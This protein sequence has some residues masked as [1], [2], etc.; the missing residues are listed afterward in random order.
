M[1][2]SNILGVCALVGGLALAPVAAHAQQQS[3]KDLM[4]GTWSLLLDDGITADGTHVPNFGP[5]P[6]GRLIFTAD[7][8]YAMEIFRSG[9]APFASKNRLSGTAEENKATVQGANA[10][11][12][13]Y[14]IDEASK[15]I[16]F[17]V[18]GSS[19]PNA[20]GTALKRTITAITPDVMTYTNPAPGAAGAV[21]G[22]VAWRKLR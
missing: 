5:N 11:F 14:A 20:D 19:F 21:R 1:Q 4:V 22:E 18:A 13:T 8:H 3:V 6:E 16:T 12:G 2:R 9:R 7:G 15:T 17:R 10:H